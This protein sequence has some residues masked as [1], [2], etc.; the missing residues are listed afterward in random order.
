MVRRFSRR[1]P[2]NDSRRRCV[3]ARPQVDP[4]NPLSPTRSGG[5]NAVI[6]RVN[7]QLCAGHKV[8]NEICPEVFALDE[9][10]YAYVEAGMESPPE[11]LW[12]K[13]REAARQCPEDA[14]VV[15]E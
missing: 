12:E 4:T 7:P 15:E 2:S 5:S 14:I 10:G 9:F 6:T 1:A 3:P 8:C 13:V 11:N